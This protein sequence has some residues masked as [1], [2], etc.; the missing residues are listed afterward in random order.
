LGSDPTALN[1][2]PTISSAGLASPAAGDEEEDGR[3]GDGEESCL[4]HFRAKPIAI[5]T[6]TTRPNICRRR[7][8]RTSGEPH[9]GQ[10]RSS[11]SSSAS[12]IS[13]KLGARA[14]EDI[15]GFDGVEVS[16]AQAGLCGAASTTAGMPA[17]SS[18]PCAVRASPGAA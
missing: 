4:R 12:S 6:V 9:A 7:D 8:D 18:T 14:S 13:L 1:L 16:D 5:A 10:M 15:A 3:G 2:N 17:E 11:S